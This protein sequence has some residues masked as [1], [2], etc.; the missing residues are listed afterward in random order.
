MRDELA[1]RL[2]SRVMG[3]DRTEVKAQLPVLQALSLVKYDEYGNYGPGVKFVESLAAWLNQFPEEDDRRVAFEFVMDELVFV[4]ET[5]IS[6]LINLVP[7]EIVAPVLRARVAEHAGLP[8]Y[9]I[10]ALES[11]PEFDRLR[12]AS[13]IVGAS[14]GARLD[15][16]RRSSPLLSHEQFV[17]G[18]T[19]NDDQ[20]KSMSKK[21]GEAQGGDGSEP[22]PFEHVFLVDDFYGS[23]RTLIRESEPEADGAKEDPAEGEP[24]VKPDGKLVRLQ[25]SLDRAT[26]LGYLVPDAPGTVVLYCA[27]E[28]ALAHLEAELANHGFGNWRVRAAMTF[29]QSSKVD[30]TNPAMADLCR[31]FADPSTEDDH[32]GFTPIGYSDCAL[33]LVLPHNTPNNSVCLLWMD[34]R[35]RPNSAKLR[36]LFPRYE[37][38]HPDRP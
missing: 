12:R 37:R 3:W 9:R 36:A 4:S 5:Q 21:L 19:W 35:D 16:L 15:R 6:H 32:K 8:T 33:P 24:E 2:L 22:A 7:A 23:G 31:R 28:Q 20:I 17:Q 26:E 13:L 10:S 14:D 34:T 25:D 29:P 38:H 27:T 18:T 11:N 30:S 1:E